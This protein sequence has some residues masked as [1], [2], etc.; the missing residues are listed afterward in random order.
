MVLGYV[1]Q[2]VGYLAVGLA[3]VAGAPEVVVGIA[4]A[5][6]NVTLTKGR[7]ADAL[8]S[9]GKVRLKVK[10]TYTPTGGLVKVKIKR[11]TLKKRLG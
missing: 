6:S 1:T 10:F 9:T 5:A 7:K 3:L 2:C 8:N 4:A 11:V